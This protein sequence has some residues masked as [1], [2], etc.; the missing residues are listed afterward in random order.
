MIILL[1]ARETGDAVDFKQQLSTTPFE[2]FE[3]EI[4][5]N[6]PIFMFLDNFPR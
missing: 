2:A 1:S 3:L 5:V 4:V 6:Y